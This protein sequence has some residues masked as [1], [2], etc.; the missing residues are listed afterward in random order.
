MHLRECLQKSCWGWGAY[1]K[2]KGFPKKI[3][4][5]RGCLKNINTLKGDTL[6]SEQLWKVI[7]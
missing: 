2:L 7:E 3:K 4:V 1:E 5:K 6:N